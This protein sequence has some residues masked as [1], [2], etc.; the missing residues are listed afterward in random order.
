[1]AVDGA[2]PAADE[3]KSAL[4][5]AVMFL[6]VFFSACFLPPVINNLQTGQPF[7]RVCGRHPVC[8]AWANV[9][10]QL[11]ADCEPAGQRYKVGGILWPC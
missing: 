4:G 10:A 6:S 8:L 1:M 9:T 3:D 11:L 5:E 7:L 2:Q